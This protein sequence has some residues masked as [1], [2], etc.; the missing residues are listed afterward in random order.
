[1][2]Y[3]APWLSWMLYMNRLLIQSSKHF[4]KFTPLPQILMLSCSWQQRVAYITSLKFI[5]V[6]SSKFVSNF[7]LISRYAV[8]KAC[9]TAMITNEKVVK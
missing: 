8:F 6:F 3:F 2:V 7:I 9:I 4:P 1:M 5:T